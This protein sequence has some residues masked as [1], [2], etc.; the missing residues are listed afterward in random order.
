MP[1]GSGSYVLL[2][3]KKTFDKADIFMVSHNGK[4]PCY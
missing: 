2:R 4:K 3:V 1:C